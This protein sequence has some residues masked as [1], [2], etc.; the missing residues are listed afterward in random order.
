MDRGPAQSYDK[1]LIGPSVFCL[2]QLLHEIFNLN[3]C[4]ALDIALFNALA[5]LDSLVMHF[6][7]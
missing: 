4:L 1:D 6:P 5:D 2:M 7:Y 3:F